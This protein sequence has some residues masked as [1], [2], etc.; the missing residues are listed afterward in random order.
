MKTT[1]ATLGAAACL[2][3]SY[4]HADMTLAAPGMTSAKS[5]KGG[6]LSKTENLGKF[7]RYTITGYEWRLVATV[8]EGGAV[9]ANTGRLILGDGSSAPHPGVSTLNASV[10]GTK[11]GGQTIVDNAVLNAQLITDMMIGAETFGSPVEFKEQSI[12]VSFEHT[13]NMP[14]DSGN[15][16]VFYGSCVK[17]PPIP[18]GSMTAPEL[19]ELESLPNI[20][21]T[22][23]REGVS[24]SNPDF[25][26]GVWEQEVTVAA[27]NTTNNGHG[28]N[29]DSIDVS[30]PGKAAEKWQ[31]EGILDTD[32]NGNGVIDDGDDDESGTT[33]STSSAGKK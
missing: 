4:A 19:V 7:W 27:P 14:G 6:S 31:A 17:D 26:P 15:Y 3:L 8:P 1:I 16:V 9:E 11:S 2:S 20:S 25:V 32:T 28:N 12:S 23:E 29:D 13:S 30:N 18:T 24:S 33:G 22:I 5:Y 10:N 21:Y